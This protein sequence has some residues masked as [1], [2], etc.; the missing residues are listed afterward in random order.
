[1]GAC[2]IEG[3]DHCEFDGASTGVGHDCAGYPRIRR[4][5]AL[6]HSVPTARVY[7]EFGE[8]QSGKYLL[9]LRL[10]TLVQS[11]SISTPASRKSK[12]YKLRLICDAAA[13]GENHEDA[14]QP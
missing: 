6:P 13:T 2:G 10:L 4:K 1:M 14:A 7:S 11:H 8:L 12:Y 9:N 3:D 5:C